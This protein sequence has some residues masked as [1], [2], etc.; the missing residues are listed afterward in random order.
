MVRALLAGRKTQTRRL[1]TSPLRRV[2]VGDRLWVKETWQAGSSDDGPCVAF[3]ADD[4]RWYPEF[5][6]PDE[7]AG[8][9]FDYDA[10]PAQAWKHGFW[11][12]DVEARGPWSSPL[13]MPRWASRLTLVVEDV[14]VEPLQAISEDDAYNEGICCALEESDRALGKPSWGD[15][16]RHDRRL[17]VEQTFGGAARAFN[18]LWDSLHDKPGQRWEDNPDVVALTFRVIRANIDRIAA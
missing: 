8:P 14:R 11:I 2:E 7:G 1:A 3:R 4:G 18:W 12:A 13:H 5:T 17:L 9:S 15:L 16:P 10:H 6:G